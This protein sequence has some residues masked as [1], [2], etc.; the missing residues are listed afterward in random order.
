MIAV[1]RIRED[2]KYD[3]HSIGHFH[4]F[5][6][7]EDRFIINQSLCGPTEYDRVCGRTGKPGQVAFMVS[8]HGIFNITP[9]G[10]EL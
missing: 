5:A 3:Y 10:S 9:F 6:V 8:K 7:I 4:H 2:K 1:D